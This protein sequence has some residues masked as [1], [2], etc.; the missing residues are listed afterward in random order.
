MLRIS[1]AESDEPAVTLRLEGQIVGPW[2]EVLRET[3][4]Q[5]LNQGRLLTL[6]V[7][8]AMFADRNGVALL[9]DLCRRSVSIRGCSPFLSEQLKS[10]GKN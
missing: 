9:L 4:E 8:E 7:S 1:G 3:T 5:L 2:V 10:A 6:D